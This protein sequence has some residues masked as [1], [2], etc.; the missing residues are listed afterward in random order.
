MGQGAITRGTVY[1]V[2]AGPGDP[3]LMTRRALELV[4]AA[5]AILYDRLVAATILDGARSDA[6]VTF[7]GKR[8][9]GESV[10]QAEITARLVD[11]ACAGRAGTRLKG[12]G[13]VIIRRDRE[14]TQTLA[15]AGGPF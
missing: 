11:L 7:A 12:G 6:E 10:P 4:A 14:E 1:L 3:V 5:D 13:P 9:G 8:P 2:G 15:A